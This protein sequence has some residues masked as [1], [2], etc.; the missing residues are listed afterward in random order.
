AGL[1]DTRS[2]RAGSPTGRVDARWLDAARGV[3]AEHMDASTPTKA[4]LID[5]AAARVEAE[6]GP[7]AGPVPSRPVAYRV[8][9]ALVRGQ[10]FAGSAKWR[11]SIATRPSGVYGRLRATRPG[12]YVL[13]DTN[14]L[15][16]YAMEQLTHRWVKV[17]LSVAMDLFTHCVVGIRLAPV[18]T[19]A[20]DVA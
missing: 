3:V 9:G 4:I 5:R 19:K 2:A 18:S 12:E 8:L 7:G 6:H 1:A 11:Q 16:V 13:L 20:V 10:G 14:S 17:E 15:D